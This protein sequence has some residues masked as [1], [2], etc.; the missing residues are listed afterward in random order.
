MKTILVTGC[1][2][3][4][5]LEIA[6]YFLDRDWNVIATM[7][8]PQDD[9]IAHSERLHIVALDITD[10][11]NIRQTLDNIGPI[12]V[13]VNNAG[14]GLLSVFEATSMET[15][16]DIFETNAFGTMAMTKA[17]IPQFRQ[18]RSGIIVNITSSVTLKPFPMLSAYT[19]SKEAITAFTESLA[20]ELKPFGI[21]LSLVIPGRSPTRF[22]E[23]AQARRKNI[24]PDAYADFA[25]SAFSELGPANG[26]TPSDVAKAVWRAV[27]DPTSPVRIAAGDDAIAL[28]VSG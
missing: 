4:F 24:I 18:Q 1:S 7:R 2:S 19:A 23:N 21:R 25:K 5:G 26:T 8:I 22:S 12:D 17:V 16:R 27:N 3:G 20:L 6:R 9:L 13:L 14:I 28:C 15:I 11:D 10:P